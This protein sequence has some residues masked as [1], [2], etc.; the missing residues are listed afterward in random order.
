MKRGRG[1]LAC[2]LVVAAIVGA[3]AAVKLGPATPAAAAP[4][5][6]VSTTWLCPH[7]G[8]AGWTATIE[9]ANPGDTPVDVRLTSTGTGG[10]RDAGEVEVPGHGDVLH[11][12][13][14][15]QRGAGTRVDVFGGWAAVGWVVW[16]S[17]KEAGL[18]AEPCTPTPGT[19]WSVVDGV[20]NRRTHSFVVVMNPFST[21]AVVNVSLFLPD[22]PPVRSTAWTDLPIEAGTS[23]AL[24]LGEKKSGA[25]G[26]QIVGAQV[27]ASRGRVAVSSL[28]VS[29]GGGIRSTMAAPATSDRWILPVSGGSGGG[30]VSLLVPGDAGVRYTGILL[31]ADTRPQ[32]AGNLADARQGATSTVLVPVHTVGAAAVLLDV[33]E[34]GTIGAALREEGPGADAAATGGVGAPATGWVVLPTAFGLDPRPSLVLVND[35]ERSIT[36]TLTLLHEGGGSLGDTTQV[37]VPATRTAEIP[38]AFLRRD[39]TAAVL[40]QADGPIVALGAGIAGS[41]DATRYAMALG[42]PIPAAA[43]PP[44][45]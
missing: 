8:G 45:P 42:V 43:S 27:I 25:L 32:T 29:D 31:A 1:W 23:I 33:T 21:D 14:A 13:P 30:T 15:T 3:E 38:G 44:S 17:A 2:L 18:G 20:T 35:G 19:S 7:G 4:G 6:A 39:H 10:E 11:E 41:G 36:A 16:A 9:I 37:S 28:A 34:G 12:V 24:D 40:I 22:R 26:E 5:D